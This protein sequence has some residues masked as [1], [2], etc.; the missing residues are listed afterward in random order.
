MLFA[1][2]A[3]VFLFAIS[4]TTFAK[5]SLLSL[6]HL[7]A[8]PLVQMC[9]WNCQ[10]HLL[11]ANPQ[12]VELAFVI[13]FNSYWILVS[14]C[15][16][17]LARILFL[18]TSLLI[19]GTGAGEPHPFFWRSFSSSGAPR[20]SCEKSAGCFVFCATVCDIFF[21]NLGKLTSVWK[22]RH[23]ARFLVLSG[24][25]FVFQSSFPH[26]DAFQNGWWKSDACPLLRWR[27]KR[28]FSSPAQ[29]LTKR[30]LHSQMTF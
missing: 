14:L 29:G 23:L 19:F 3:L 12:G 27:Y 10:C 30:R 5:Q 7:R 6:L 28:C 4:S 17:Q 2:E 8:L 26:N 13:I 20:Y 24:E 22:E 11:M 18:S 15:G 1:G 21:V 16:N 9:H 25:V